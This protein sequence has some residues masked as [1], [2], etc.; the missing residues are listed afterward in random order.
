MNQSIVQPRG[1]V[2]FPAFMAE[3]VYMQAF[4][5]NKALPWPLERWQATVDQMLEGIDVDLAYLM[6]DQKE[7]VVGDPHRRPGL[8]I[9]GYWCA[10]DRRHG[11]GGSHVGIS[12]HGS[13]PPPAQPGH[14]GGGRHTGLKASGWQ[15]PSP[16]ATVDLSQPEATILATNVTASR[17]FIGKYRGKPGEG[18][19]CSHV[20]TRHLGEI[21]LSKGICW[22]GNVAMLHESLP[23]ESDCRRTLVRIT[24]PGWSPQ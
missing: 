12:A 21:Q 4:N 14:G 22:A 17:A 16:W 24:V 5:P 6:I 9:D 13:T 20:E 1:L 19:D 2:T 23:V 15:T 18:G 10:A 8:H 11:G 3:K 7:L